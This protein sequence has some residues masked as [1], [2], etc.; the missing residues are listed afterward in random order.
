MR[1][2]GRTIPLSSSRAYHPPVPVTRVVY[3]I[4]DS[5]IGT[6]DIP[7]RP[8][9]HLRGMLGDSVYLK[10]HGVDGETSAQVLA[11]LER[12][13]IGRHPKPD[14]CIVLAGVND[15]QLGAS[16]SSIVANLEATYRALLDAGVHPIA[17]TIYPFGDYIAWTGAGEA[18]RQEVRAWMQTELPSTLP[19]VE[20]IDLEDVI[21]DLSEKNRPRLRAEYA[22]D[23][24]LHTNNAGAEVVAR[25]LVERSPT[26]SGRQG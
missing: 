4:G 2:R 26:L 3:A 24:G 17:L 1:P 18:V 22:G 9:F 20:V 6:D 12:D 5:S 14:I 15:I 16:S 23:D 21:G 13:V 8:F 11:R 19:A 25:A 10:A 7:W